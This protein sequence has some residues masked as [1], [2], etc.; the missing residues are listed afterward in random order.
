MDAIIELVDSMCRDSADTQ[1]MIISKT[2]NLCNNVALIFECFHDRQDSKW[3][4]KQHESTKPETHQT[5]QVYDTT[6]YDIGQFINL[7]GYTW[8]LVQMMTW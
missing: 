2:L 1:Y 8:I 4:D 6:C 7:C 5:S 3:H